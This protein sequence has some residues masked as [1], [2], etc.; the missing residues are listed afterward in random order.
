MNKAAQILLIEDDTSLAA[1][2][3]DV[4]KEDG[5]L[6]TVCHRG[7]EGLRRA[8]K[9]EW[10]VV[11]TDLRLPGLGGLELVQQLHETQPRLPVVLMTAHGTIETAIEATKLG[12]YDY[13]QKPFE[14]PGLISVLHRAVE[15]S[16]LM[17]ETVTLPDAPV[18][19]RT[20]LVG[21]SRAMQD[22][23]KEI[24]RVAAKPVTVLIRGE[25]GTGKE[26]IA[27][28]IY[29]HSPRAK[30]PFIAINCAAIPENLLESELF[31]HERGAFTGAD[32]RRIGRFEQSNKGTLFLDEIGDLPPNTQVKLL[33]VLQ[34]Q[35]FQRVGG[36]EVVSVDVRVLAATHRNLEAM[37]REGKFRE[38]LFHRLNVVCL[39]LP[40]LRERREDIPVLVQH[41][42][43]KY[44]GDFGVESPAIASDAVAVLQADPW[45][46]NVRELE[47]MTRRLL[48]GARGLS[49]NADAVRQTLAA[50]NAEAA[51]TGRSFA[52]FAGDLLARAQK[53][54]LEDAHARMLAEA[55]R[56]IL[57]QAIALAEGNQAKAARWLGLSR[58]TLREKLK[59]LGLHPDT[60]EANSETNG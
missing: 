4:L 34:Q 2:L 31:G 18:G 38:D 40:P 58:F 44:A 28:A 49:I 46:G 7:D 25:T 11:L 14:M 3:G 23:Y 15:A 19:S 17:H 12:A 37:I 47:N 52:A 32:Q 45:P 24:G 26:L 55:E 42:L 9:D 13:L 56:E 8:N 41:F 57:T 30:A 27:R 6:V 50:R 29:Q 1:N 36:T 54:G 48:L 33:R 39:Q 35:T 60:T 51:L 16:R 59:Q 10:D 22:V 21:T 20:A 5:F 43:H 53:G